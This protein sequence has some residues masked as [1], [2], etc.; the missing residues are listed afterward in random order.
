MIS[1]SV[2]NKSLILFRRDFDPLFFTET[3]I[4]LDLKF[5]YLGAALLPWKY[6]LSDCHVERPIVSVLAE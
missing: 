1:I 2:L 3:L 4:H 6:V 5:A